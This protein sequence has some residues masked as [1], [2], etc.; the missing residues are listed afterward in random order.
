MLLTPL[1]SRARP[2]IV[3]SLRLLLNVEPRML[4]VYSFINS[5]LGGQYLIQQSAWWRCMTTR[6]DYE[7]E[8]WQV[9][10]KGDEENIMAT[11]QGVCCDEYE[12]GICVFVFYQGGGSIF[13]TTISLMMMHDNKNGQLE[14]TMSSRQQRQQGK[15]NGGKVGCLLQWIWEGDLCLFSIK[16][17]GQ[18]I[19]FL[20]IYC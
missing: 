3:P 6:T 17:G 12:R 4:W 2:S 18:L 8:Q 9:E 5:K 10:K 16:G 13:N 11:R 15:Y 19:N 7:K 1:A 14:R 20:F